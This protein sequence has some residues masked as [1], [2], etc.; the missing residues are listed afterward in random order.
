MYYVQTLGGVPRYC[1]SNE[2][3]HVINSN[4]STALHGTAPYNAAQYGGARYGT[5]GH[6]TARRC[7]AELTLSRATEL[8]PC[9]MTLRKHSK[10]K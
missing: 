5:D 1:S 10:N 9:T 6:G 4:Y 8:R 2:T 7:S 3:W